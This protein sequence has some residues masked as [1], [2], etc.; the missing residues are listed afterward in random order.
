MACKFRSTCLKVSS[1]VIF[2]LFFQ[3]GNAQYDFG[4]VNSKF[5]QYEKE[6]GGKLTIM[7]YKDG[8]TLYS[9]SSTDFLPNTQAPVGHSSEWLTTALVMAL[10]DEG[11]LSLD[12]KISKYLPI[13]GSYGK[14]YITIRHCLTHTTGIAGDKLMAVIMKSNVYPTLEAT[15][16]AYAA[17]HEIQ[18]NPSTEF[19]YSN[20]GPDIAGRIAEIVGKREFEQLV[21]QLLLRPLGMRNT[22]FQF[23][24]D[25]GVSPSTG[26]Y[27]SA[28]DYINFLTMLL[29]K[30]MFK[31]KRV[32]S[33][34]SVEFMEQLQ[35]DAAKVKYAP[36][37]AEGLGYANGA[38]VAEQDSKGNAT[39]FTV[40]SLTGTWPVMDVCR[41]YACVIFAKGTGE[42]E[43]KD[44]FTEIKQAIAG[45]LQCNN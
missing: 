34:A 36:K 45:Q 23:D 2:L 19:K 40:P 30:G 24:Y 35:V 37:G 20:I 43:N 13:F 12:D 5:L 18:T 25:K 28:A 15:V 32:L 42:E 27:S 33:E 16:N 10:V 9:K 8:K 31:G 17:K 3:F 38:W 44:V 1:L 14:G 29:G 4:G 26:A 11:K 41:G 21:Q 6:S 7:I 39:C 22:T